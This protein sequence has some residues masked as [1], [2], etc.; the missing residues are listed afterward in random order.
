MYNVGNIVK[1]HINEALN[2]NE[3]ISD[4]RMKICKVCPI[5]S[6]RFGG[7]C[8]SKLWL[9]PETG[10]VSLESLPG[11]VRGCACRLNAKTRILDETCPA[12]KW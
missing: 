5:Y 10:E 3:D 4:K 12:K 8:N 1:G 11:F 9:N 2:L 6:D 7:I